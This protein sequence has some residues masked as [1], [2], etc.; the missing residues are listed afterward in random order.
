MAPTDRLES[1]KEIAAYLK[2]DVRTV[3]RWEASESLPVHRHQHKKRG[4]VYAHPSELDAWRD[5]RRAE[6]FTAP[7]A[8]AAAA[9]PLPDPVVS[10]SGDRRPFAWPW[11]AGALA[12]AAAAV[13]GIWTRGSSPDPPAVSPVVVAD[14]PRL[15]GEALRDGGTLDRIA[16]D[17]DG[18]LLAVTP[19]GATLFVSV[20]GPKGTRLDAIDVRSKAINW[21]IAGLS[22]CGP[23][24]VHP[25]GDRVIM[26]DKTEIVIIDIRTQAIRRIPTPAASLRDFALMPDGRT[27]YVAAAF[28]GLLSVDTDSGIAQILT[29]LPCPIHLALTP[30]ADRLF[31]NYQCSGPG[32]SRGHDSIEVFDTASNTSLGVIKGLPNV[33]GDTVVTPDGSQVWADGLDACRSSYYDN[34]GCPRGHGAIVNVIRTSDHTLLRS[35]RVGPDD[36]SNVRLSFSPD[37]SRV[38]AGR[39]QTTVLSTATL[40]ELESSPWTLSGNVVFAQDGRTAYAMLGGAT[41]IAVLPIAAHP[42]PPPGLTARWMFDGTGTDAAGGNDLGRVAR[43]AFS[44]GRVGLSLR[45]PNAPEIRIASPPNLD[46]DQEQFTAMAW[47]KVAPPE[48][49]DRP[50]TVL[51]YVAVDSRGQFGWTLLRGPDQRAVVCLGWFERNRCDP[52]NS[53]LVRGATAL[54]PG[55]WHHIAI[56]RAGGTLTLFVDGKADGSGAVKAGLPTLNHLWMRLGSDEAGTSPLVGLLDEIEIYGRA[57]T[58]EEVFTRGK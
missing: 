55:S 54:A 35:L 16:I 18:D 44:P 45:F 26:S 50:M 46:I 19:D 49:G 48:A 43:E 3:Q 29:R 24:I 53:A 30:K 4:S 27:L 22:G 20:C 12:L 13:I 2:R 6:L 9:P 14:A 42:A 47:V 28:Q 36:E 41:S 15:F 40:T 17:G 32:G 34:A 5:S 1:W 56:T 21:R 52:A 39:A 38:V 25:R 37:G 8:D 57:L 51:E 31:V 11:L 7:E 10:V 33:G 23:L 58:P